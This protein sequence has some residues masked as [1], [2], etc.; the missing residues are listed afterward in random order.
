M[1]DA[2]QK[3]W[4]G[5]IAF[6]FHFQFKKAEAQFRLWLRR[7]QNNCASVARKT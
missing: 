4:L 5:H 2:T 1:T 6:I 7:P 3:T